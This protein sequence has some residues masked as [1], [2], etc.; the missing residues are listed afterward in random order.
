[1][2]VLYDNIQLM[3]EGRETG[4][5][6]LFVDSLSQDMIGWTLQ[7]EQIWLAVIVLDV[8]RACQASWSLSSFNT[9]PT[10]PTPPAPYGILIAV[11]LKFN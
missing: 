7:W 2:T 6:M 11:S 1:M 10:T 4:N 9:N 5:K 3:V 8:T